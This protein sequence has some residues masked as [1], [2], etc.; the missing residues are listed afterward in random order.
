MSALFDV[1]LP[2]FLVVG[3]WLCRVLAPDAVRGRRRRHQRVSA[4]NFAVPVLLFQAIAKLDLGANFDPFL[5]LAFIS[6][7]SCPL[8]PGFQPALLAE[9][10]D[11]GSHCHRL[12]LPVL[13][14]ASA[15]HP[16]HRTRL[17]SEAL[18]GNF[19][20]ISIHSPLLYTFGITAMEFA[21]AHGK[22]LS[23]GRVVP[24]ALS[25]CCIR[26]WSSAFCAGW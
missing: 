6:A 9:A 16:D 21:R 23:I 22:N 14:L 1:I 24:G 20:I 11:R 13:E 18:L 15:G 7:P 12:C 26:R 4:Q 3:F 17:W 25:G 10:P 19:T 8:P 5:L 2:V